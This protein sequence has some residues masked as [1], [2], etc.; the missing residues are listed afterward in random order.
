MVT[1]KKGSPGSGK[2]PVERRDET[3]REGERQQKLRKLLCGV[4]K[5]RKG[6]VT[7]F[8]CDKNTR[9]KKGASENVRSR[10]I[11]PRSERLSSSRPMRQDHTVR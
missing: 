1:K 9:Q 3:K 8:P 6:V 10:V 4:D 11:K 2:G 5:K 7:K